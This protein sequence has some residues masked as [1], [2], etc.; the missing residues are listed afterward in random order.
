MLVL[1][2]L[3][4]LHIL[5]KISLCILKLVEKFVLIGDD[6]LKENTHVPINYQSSYV[7]V[8]SSSLAPHIRDPSSPIVLQVFI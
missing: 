2:L 1:M 7:L 4:S 6:P 3:E 8:P 5:K